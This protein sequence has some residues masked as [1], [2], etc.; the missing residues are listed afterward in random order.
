D[1]NPQLH[2]HT[3]HHEHLDI[4]NIK[5]DHKLLD[6]LD[7][8]LEHHQ[9]LHELKLCDVDFRHRKLHDERFEQQH[10][11]CQQHHLQ[12]SDGQQ[13]DDC[14]RNGDI[15]VLHLEYHHIGD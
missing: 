6:F 4:L 3:H 10:R 2:N 9:I 11:V 1:P 15:H 13:H 8:K 14:K 5:D 7:I 12:F